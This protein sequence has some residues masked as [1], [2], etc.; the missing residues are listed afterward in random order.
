MSYPRLVQLVGVSGWLLGITHER[1]TGFQC[2]LVN[3]QGRVLN[4][5]QFH[6]TEAEASQAGRAFIQVSQ[7]SGKPQAF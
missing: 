7:R 3:P 5:R 1:S 4:D 6:S 2:W